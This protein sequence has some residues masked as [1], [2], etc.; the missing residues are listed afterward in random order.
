MSRRADTTKHLISVSDGQDQVGTLVERGGEYL[1]YDLVGN[2]VGSFPNQ[3]T[4]ARSLPPKTK[5]SPAA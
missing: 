1:A 2:L 4:A 3:L 5:R